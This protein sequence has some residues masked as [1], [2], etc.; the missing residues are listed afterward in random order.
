MWANLFDKEIKACK[1]KA[2]NT[3]S[4]LVEGHAIANAFPLALYNHHKCTTTKQDMLTCPPRQPQHTS[5]LWNCRMLYLRCTCSQNAKSGCRGHMLWFDQSVWFMLSN[6]DC[7]FD[8]RYPSIAVKYGAFITWISA[9]SLTAVLAQLTFMAYR[10]LMEVVVVEFAAKPTEKLLVKYF[11]ALSAQQVEHLFKPAS[12]SLESAP[13]LSPVGYRR[14]CL[15]M[16]V[17][18]ED[19]L[20]NG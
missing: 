10:R 7:F 18:L 9:A 13:S 12:F 19:Q 2:F 1:D 11:D 16:N 15:N 20:N 8:S 4:H 14:K 17:T 6:L 3:S 5:K